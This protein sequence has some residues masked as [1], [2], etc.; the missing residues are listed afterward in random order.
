MLVNAGTAGMPAGWGPSEHG[1]LSFS[2]DGQRLFL[3]TAELAKAE[4]KDAPEPMKVDLW[5][6]KDPELQSVQKVKADKERQRNYRAVLHLPAAGS[7]SPPRLVQLARTELPTVVINDNAQIALG[8][9]CP[10]NLSHF[11]SG[12]KTLEEI[13][14][15]TRQGIQLIPGASGM[16]ELAALSEVQ[17]AS[18]VQSFG[19]LADEVVGGVEQTDAFLADFR[20]TIH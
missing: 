8:C 3:G 4:P 18:I 2:K 7:D 6:Y 12:Q 19:A 13:T 10:Y 16:Q 17:A 15:K 1:A 9:Q 11:L 20:R 14:L 5:H